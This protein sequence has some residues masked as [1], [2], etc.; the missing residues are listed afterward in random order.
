MPEGDLV[1][2][3]RK[4]FDGKPREAAQSLIPLAASTRALVIGK[5]FRLK[6]EGVNPNHAE[7]AKEKAGRH[8]ERVIDEFDNARETIHEL[9]EAGDT[10]LVLAMLA[11]NAGDISTTA[12]VLDAEL[13]E[14][15]FDKD[16]DMNSDLSGARDARIVNVCWT[17]IMETPAETK[18][19]NEFFLKTDM[20]LSLTRE[21][22]YLA[23][24]GATRDENI[25]QIL[26]ALRDRRQFVVEV[27][28]EV[29]DH[30][31]EAAVEEN[32]LLS[33]ESDDEVVKDDSPSES[34][35]N[36]DDEADDLPDIPD[37]GVED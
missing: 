35:D 2:Q 33:N 32:V 11:G 15:F 22:E 27:A 36:N 37:G 4:I 18:G 1:V 29:E 31:T 20:G 30:E 10:D 6:L 7:D 26:N 25:D 34:S 23:G 14:E 19:V 21:L 16:A 28:A 9:I 24:F 3:A 5:A 17:L 12:E 13:I 8:L